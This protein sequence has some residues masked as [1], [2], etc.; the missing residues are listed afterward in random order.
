MPDTLTLVSFLFLLAA[1]VVM[2]FRFLRVRA[3]SS[4]PPRVFQTPAF[5]HLVPPEPV[6]WKDPRKVEAIQAEIVAQDFTK[7]G[8]YQIFEMPDVNLAAFFS[9]RHTAAAILYEHPTAGIWVDVCVEYESGESLTVSNAPAGG[10]L[11]H[12]PGQE[13]VY[14]PG[15]SVAAL[16]EK[17]LATRKPEPCRTLT[18]ESF[19]HVFQDHYAEEMRWRALRGG[20]TAEEIRRVAEASGVELTEGDIDSV[21]ASL[22]AKA[23]LPCQ[24]SG[25]CLYDG[26]KDPERAIEQ[27]PLVENDPRT[28]PT[29]GRICPGFMEELAQA[30]GSAP[31]APRSAS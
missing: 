9:A 24:K 18:A 12:M 28:C 14:V 5:I 19:P 8:E 17:V 6:L 23:I 25:E 29:H 10:D 31:T 22:E 7:L 2:V 16:V 30:N 20:T 4:E 15:S 26:K 3:E 21:R 1:G 13:K 27:M 11:D